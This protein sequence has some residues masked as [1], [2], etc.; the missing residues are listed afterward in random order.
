MSYQVCSG[1]NVSDVNPNQVL[2]VCL[3][4]NNVLLCDGSVQ[5]VSKARREA[6]QKG[7]TSP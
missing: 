2:A 3:I 4:H 7:G 6:M 5:G 1:K